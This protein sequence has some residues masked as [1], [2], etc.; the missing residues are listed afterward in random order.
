MPPVATPPPPIDSWLNLSM[1]RLLVGTADHGSLSA[2]AR[3]AGIA[4]SNASRS[5]RTLERRLGY[6]LLRRSTR[7][8]TLTPQGV[9]TVEWAREVLDGVDRLA[10]GAEALVHRG[11]DELSIGSSM[12]IAEHLLPGWIGAFRAR[13]P[14]VATRLTVMNSAQVIAAV[15]GGEVALGFVETPDLP[16]G[17]Q[18]I[19]VYTDQLVVVA[20]PGHPW[21]QRDEPLEP[22]ELAV[23]ALVEREEG[24]GTRAF[25]D[26]LVDDRRPA[27]LVE[28]N[29]NA[30]I[31]Q[32]VVEGIGPA[33]LSR[34]AVAG[35]LRSGQLVQVPTRGR[36]LD[37][38]L[39]AIWR[40]RLPDG[41][42][43]ASFVEVARGAERLPE[44]GH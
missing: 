22:A 17:L 8:S 2:S 35:S 6:T 39:Q 9:L 28:L 18:H 3:A 21:A 12:T 33:V 27:P 11:R 13:R 37:R 31:C 16:A 24:S 41:G 42:A 36:Q 29:S 43:A 15:A 14:D 25:L 40:G 7:G 30:A 1:L 19:T 5:L 32:A 38:T 4:Q 10:A 20:G 23:T 26:R 34:L 44:A